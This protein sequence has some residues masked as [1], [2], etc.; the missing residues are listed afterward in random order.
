MGRSL[1]PVDRA[2]QAQNP[3]SESRLTADSAPPATITL[4]SPSAIS[5][6]ASPIAC[7]PVEQAVTTA[8]LGPFEIVSDRDL[9][10]HQIDEPAGNEKRRDAARSFFM[11]GHGGV[12]DAA[13][14][15]DSRA[16]QDPGLDLLLI[17][18]GRPFGVAQRLRRGAHAVN[19]EVVDPALLLGLHPVVGVEGVGRVSTRHLRG[20]L[21]GQVRNVEVLDPR[22]PPTRWPEAGA[23]SPRRRKPS[24][25]PCQDR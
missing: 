11:Q 4:A 3:A 24:G 23:T 18:L 14:S 12:V 19:D 2:R 7:A 15:A 17:G 25:S 16:D 6:P 13:K 21:A 10:A 22:R 1:K 9:A 20:D 5:R 8:W